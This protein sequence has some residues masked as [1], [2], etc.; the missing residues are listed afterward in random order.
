MSAMKKTTAVFVAV[1][2][3]TV[4]LGVA[5]SP[6]AEAAGPNEAT[7]ATPAP[8][9]NDAECPSGSVEDNIG[10]CRK[11]VADV[12]V[13]PEGALGV[14]GACYIFVDKV[15]SKTGKMV[16]RPGSVEDSKGYCRKPVANVIVC[17]KG[18]LGVPGG[19]YIIVAKVLPK[20]LKAN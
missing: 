4:T 2:L 1:L 6:T 17:P 9:G 20:V 14:P 5:A 11:P 3:A 8:Q 12:I 7:F 10:K 13:C 18:A 16:C 15:E 19:C